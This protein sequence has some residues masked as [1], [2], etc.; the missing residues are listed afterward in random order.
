MASDEPRVT[1][2]EL[3]SDAACPGAKTDVTGSV[4]ACL[5]PGTPGKVTNRGP[6]EDRRDTETEIPCLRIFFS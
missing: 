3:D 1:G 2:Q 5:V 4:C 6:A